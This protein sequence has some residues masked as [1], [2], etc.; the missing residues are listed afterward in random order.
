MCATLSS[1]CATVR[2]SDIATSV[3]GEALTAREP[4]VGVTRVKFE[5]L[6]QDY[7]DKLADQ[8]IKP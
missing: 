4:F 5:N 3:S 1:D 7:Q 6:I 2:A 8:K